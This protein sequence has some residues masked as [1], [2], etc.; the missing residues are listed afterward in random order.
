MD[1]IY[2]YPT[3]TKYTEDYE[4]LNAFVS[5]KKAPLK[6][7]RN[8][9]LKEHDSRYD[10]RYGEIQKLALEEMEE[11]DGEYNP[12]KRTYYLIT[13][14]CDTESVDEEEKIHHAGHEHDATRAWNKVEI[15]LCSA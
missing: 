1:K 13:T 11:Y 10:H 12:T 9:H 6:V 8:F 14:D 3:Y 5:D 7:L 4:E 15:E 2:F